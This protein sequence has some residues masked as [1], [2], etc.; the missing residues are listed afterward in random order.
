MQNAIENTQT[1]IP[2]HY[3]TLIGERPFGS[4]W[5]RDFTEADFELPWVEA[6]VPAAVRQDGCRYFKLDGD[7]YRDAFP[8]ATLGAVPFNTLSPNLQREV[9]REEGSHGPELRLYAAER[10]IPTTD[11]AWL[12]VGLENGAEVVF[13]AH[14]GPVMLPS[15]KDGGLLDPKL[16]YAVKVE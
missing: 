3:A 10:N 6:E 16:P 8:N 4:Q 14:P 2:D 5:G 1:L 13:T 7:A 11:E 15:P 12:I 9:R